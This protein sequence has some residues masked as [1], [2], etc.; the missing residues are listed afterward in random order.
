MVI[1]KLDRAS[2]LR[3]MNLD[4]LPPE[5]TDRVVDGFIEHV[6][7]QVAMRVSDEL[8]GLKRMRFRTIFLADDDVATWSWIAKNV[9]NVG[10]LIEQEVDRC[11][12]EMDDNRRAI[13]GDT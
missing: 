2:L 6:Q 5:Q 4:A 10:A 8:G 12:I 7:F 3:R 1:L 11:L 13:L 9:P